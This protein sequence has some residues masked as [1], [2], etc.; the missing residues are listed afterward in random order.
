MDPFSEQVPKKVLKYGT[1]KPRPWSVA[2]GSRFKSIES[3]LVPEFRLEL[4]PRRRLEGRPMHGFK[5][6]SCGSKVFATFRPVSE[7]T[8]QHGVS[9]TAGQGRLFPACKFPRCGLLS[10]SIRPYSKEV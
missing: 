9:G 7:P 8:S 10:L 5:G 6:Q 1:P 2:D 3:F 4:F